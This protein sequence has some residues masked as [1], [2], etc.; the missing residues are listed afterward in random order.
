VFDADALGGGVRSD[1][2]H[3]HHDQDDAGRRDGRICGGCQPERV[4]AVRREMGADVVVVSEL[5][6][7]AEC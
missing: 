1:G 4:H 7:K 2:D 6:P 3:I 5:P